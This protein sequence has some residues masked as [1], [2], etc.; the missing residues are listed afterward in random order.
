MLLFG[1]PSG[2]IEFDV[3]TK[4]LVVIPL[5]VE[6]D[7]Q[8]NFSYSVIR[9]EGGGPGLLFVPMSGH[10]AQ[11]WKRKLDCD[12]VASWV[13]GRTIELDNLLSLDLSNHWGIYIQGFAEENNVVFLWV[14]GSLFMVQ[15]DSLQFKKLYNISLCP[16]SIK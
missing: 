9:A 5:P 8:C 15:L 16:L 10:S 4:S 7:S 1:N 6:L 13:L 12:G 14:S 3:D 2:I 11:L